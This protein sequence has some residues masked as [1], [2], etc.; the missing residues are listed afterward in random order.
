MSN[1]LITNLLIIGST[2]SLFATLYPKLEVRSFVIH[3]II[4]DRENL[5]DKQQEWRSFLKENT[6]VVTDLSGI[7]LCVYMSSVDDLN[8]LSELEKNN[9][10]TLLIGSGAVIDW[11]HG[12]I[13]MNP[14]IEGKL[15]ASMFATTTIHPGFYL[16]GS[17]SKDVGS[18]LHIETIRKIF[19]QE[20]LTFN[21]GKPKY[22]TSMSLLSELII[23]WLK[24][25]SHYKGHQLAFGSTRAYTRRE[26]K[27]NKNI[28]REHLYAGEMKKTHQLSLLSHDNV[29]EYFHQ[30]QTWCKR[31]S[32]NMLSYEIHVTVNELHQQQLVDYCN[33]NSIKYV[34]CQN[35]SG[36]Y[37]KQCM[38]SDK[39]TFKGVDI[40]NA[41]EMAIEVAKT[42]TKDMK[43]NGL[44]VVRTKVEQ[45]ISAGFKSDINIGNTRY[46]ESHFKVK[47]E[48]RKRLNE[49]HQLLKDT[50]LYSTNAGKFPH[51]NRFPREELL[52]IRKYNMSWNI[53]NDIV[54]EN[55]YILN[56]AGFKSSVHREMMVYDDNQDLDKGWSNN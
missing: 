43:L 17:N 35:S 9:I 24:R 2:S 18:G 53:F 37:A 14:Y 31:T 11:K 10:P 34:Y 38:I 1:L 51:L 30:A 16:P 6:K 20:D 4:R 41:E 25:P 52:T 36:A 29:S 5:N 28:D 45:M 13:P 23:D 32:L 26:I 7:D 42:H 12:R 44:D 54:Q 22:V 50:V 27:E 55:R 15:R 48:S 39:M 33:K 56:N 21:Y 40:N 3:T 8:Q 19:G 49:L 46:F 47:V